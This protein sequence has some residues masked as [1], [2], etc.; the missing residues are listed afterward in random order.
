MSK[1]VKKSIR[2]KNSLTRDQRM[3]RLTLIFSGITLVAAAALGLSKALDKS[4][5]PIWIVLTLTA[6]GVISGT[7]GKIAEWREKKIRTEG[8]RR[9]KLSSLLR[10]AMHSERLPQVDDLSVTELGAT[11]TRY[12]KQGVDQ[13][14]A[15]T[16]IDLK[17]QTALRCATPPFPFI[18]LHGDSKA[19][20]SRTMAE[21]VKSEW[22]AA[23]IVLPKD[24]ES[25]AALS[26]LEPSLNISR[27]PA[28][29][30]IDD[31]TITDLTYLSSAVLEEW[32][33]RAILVATMTTKR[34]KDGL[35]T[36]AEFGTVARDALYRAIAYELPFDLTSD[37]RHA[38]QQLY[39]QENINRNPNESISIGET[40]V[41]G[42]ELIRKLHAGREECPAG[43]AIVRAAVDARRAGLFRPISEEELGKLFPLY[44]RQVNRGI[45]PTTEQFSLGLRWAAEPVAS[46]VAILQQVSGDKW[47]VL[48]YIVEAETGVHNHTRRPLPN[49]LW[50]NLL[51]ATTPA[52]AMSIGVAA[53]FSGQLDTSHAAM[54]RA[55]TYERHHFM[56]TYNLAAILDAQGNA[57]SAK[58]LYR[59]IINTGHP[60]AAPRAMVNLA[61]MMSKAGDRIG[62]QVVLKQAI[63]TNHPDMAPRAAFDMGI[64]FAIA[65]DFEN[66]QRCFQQAIDTGHLDIVPHAMYFL[67]TV[68]ESQNKADAAK[69]A[70]LKAIESAHIDM[71]PRATR[72]LAALLDA[73]GDA[74]GAR[75]AYLQAINSG[76]PDA[77]AIAALNFGSFLTR[78]GDEVSA[79]AAFQ[80]AIDSGHPQ[81]APQA[82][83]NLGL[84]LLRQ[85]DRIGARAAFEM[86]AGSGD[87]AVAASAM[88]NMGALF[89]EDGDESSAYS[90]LQLVV[91][92]KYPEAALN[93][94]YNLG[95]LLYKQGDVTGGLAALQKAADSDY[96]D[97]AQAAKDVLDRLATT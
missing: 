40:L 82:M 88:A 94:S 28:I 97:L 31:L 81:A 27:S 63:G 60:E 18:L 92:S 16:E 90:T 61:A 78:H 5:I 76:H 67:G 65:E 12:S 68:L 87:S 95:L 54:L 84:I 14:V 8:D 10:P 25:L 32:S 47:E 45:S 93:A 89:M 37:E 46:Q 70:Y 20:K 50:R 4:D 23:P 38:A 91:N 6:I 51:E 9:Q 73:Q 56:A 3:A 58:T 41:A 80:T 34:Y 19:G 35:K 53:F 52:D 2:L 26:L 7:L 75:T 39:P 22:P 77:A 30:W 96:P 83:L 55:Q 29:V 11:P 85:G 44:L 33:A 36:G 17:L 21:A 59:Q 48:D 24:G 69:N 62:A 1:R 66:S 71:A 74:D 72:S 13:Y 57:E 86:A 79:R 15:R 43:Q 64:N 49:F 42:D